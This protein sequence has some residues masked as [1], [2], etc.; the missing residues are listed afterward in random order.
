MLSFNY[1]QRDNWKEF[2]LNPVGGREVLPAAPANTYL[3]QDD[4]VIFQDIHEKRFI[5]L[6]WKGLV[7]GVS[8]LNYPL[9]TKSSTIT[10]GF[11]RYSEFMSYNCERKKEIAHEFKIDYVYSSGFDCRYFKEIAI[12]TEN[13]HLYEFV[14]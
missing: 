14:D 8:T 7:I 9:E 4:L 11:L 3:H 2:K 6:P 13:I 10:N 12:S 5:S 1:T